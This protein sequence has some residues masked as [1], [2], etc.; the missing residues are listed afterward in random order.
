[1][2]EFEDYPLY[3]YLPES[4]G[5]YVQPKI[6]KDKQ[7]LDEAMKGSSQNRFGEAWK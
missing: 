3:F 1:M 4:D 2:P 5:S 6:L 7:E